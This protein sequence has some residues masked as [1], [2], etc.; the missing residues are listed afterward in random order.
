M[1]VMDS[2]SVLYYTRGECTDI[3][4]SPPEAK[5][6][7]VCDHIEADTAMFYIYTELRK[8]GNT[9]P[10][11][12]DSEDM[13]VV[14]LSAYASSKVDGDLMIKRKKGIFDSRRLCDEEMKKVIIRFHVMTGCDTVSSFYGIGKKAVW[15]NVLRSQEAKDLLLDFSDTAL[16]EFVIKYVYNDKN[17]VTLSEMREKRWG[18]MKKKSLA[19]AGIDE[20]TSLL[21]KKRVR[22]QSFQLENFHLQTNENSP[23]LNAGYTMDGNVCIP[24]RYAQQALPDKILEFSNAAAAERNVAIDDENCDESDAERNVAIDDENCDKSDAERNVS[25]DENCDESED[26]DE[27]DGE[28]DDIDSDPDI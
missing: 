9:E 24:I 27:A 17:S 8:D 16:N 18:R 7:L 3:S 21:R 10:V 28:G 14:V 11:V 6:Q 5:P 12:I 20:D 15:K 23:V 4:V 19:R 22:Y 25:I 26:E 1:A 2:R 13:D